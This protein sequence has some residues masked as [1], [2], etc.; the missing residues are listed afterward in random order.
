MYIITTKDNNAV[1]YT[2]Q[3]VR[4]TLHRIPYVFNLKREAKLKKAELTQ[5]SV[6]GSYQILEIQSL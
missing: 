5:T 3:D 4:G 6:R 2:I 1:M